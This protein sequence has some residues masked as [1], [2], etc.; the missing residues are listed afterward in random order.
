MIRTKV[1]IVYRGRRFSWWFSRFVEMG[2]CAILPA[3][4]FLNVEKASMDKI[5]AN[6]EIL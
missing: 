2:V 1:R 6:E 3:V 5:L 4:R